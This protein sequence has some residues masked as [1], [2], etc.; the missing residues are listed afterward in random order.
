MDVSIYTEQ[1]FL[2]VGQ[3]MKQ[4]FGSTSSNVPVDIC[5]IFSYLLLFVFGLS[6]LGLLFRRR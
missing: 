5:I 3:I 6:I 1:P 2:D 4:W